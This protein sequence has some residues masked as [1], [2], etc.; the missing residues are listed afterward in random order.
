MVN[1]A[2]ADDPHYDHDVA[3][4]TVAAKNDPTEALMSSADVR[5]SKLGHAAFGWNEN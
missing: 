4:K 3:Q 2:R 1:I 5:G